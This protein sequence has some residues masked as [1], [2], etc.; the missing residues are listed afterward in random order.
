MPYKKKKCLDCETMI[1][2][3]KALRCR[4]CFAIIRRKDK[5]IDRSM[6]QR[7]WSLKKKYGISLA[8]FNKMYREQDEK[9]LICTKQ[10]ELPTATQGQGL[11]IV[12]V[13]HCHITGLVRGLLCNACN[14]GIGLLKDDISL[15]EQSI[16]YL[17]DS[18]EQKACNNKKNG[19]NISDTKSG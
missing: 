10:M 1:T 7:D 12:A 16:K 19:E 18:H 15:L 11:D 2:G 8:D 13:D 6:Y 5:D 3:G 4:P 9:C 17:K 14:K